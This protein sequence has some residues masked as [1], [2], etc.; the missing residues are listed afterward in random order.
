MS[1]IGKQPVIIPTGTEVNVSGFTVSVKGPK[2]ELKR[3]I[4]PTI[5]IEVVDQEVRLMPKAETKESSA[6]WGTSTSHVKNMVTGVNEMFEKKLIVEGVGFKVDVQGNKLVMQL[7]FSHP[8]E[9][10]IPEGIS[11]TVEKNT[12]TI[13]GIDKE[14]VGSFASRVRINKKP[15]PY[16]GKGIRYHDE[17]VR[18]KQGKKAA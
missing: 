9:M 8:V 18:R 4:H 3:D 17:V 10:E 13:T 1:R 15:E 7:G 2:G 16:K 5:A 12:I 11:V 14:L 6:L